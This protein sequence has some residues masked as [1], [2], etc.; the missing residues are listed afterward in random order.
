M[1]FSIYHVLV[2]ATFSRG[3]GKQMFKKEICLQGPVKSRELTWYIYMEMAVD[4]K[5]RS[6]VMLVYLCLRTALH[7][8]PFNYNWHDSTLRQSFVLCSYIVANP[9]LRERTT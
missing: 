7:K 8:H 4:E 9:G 2:H 5:S 1:N 6:L 3:S